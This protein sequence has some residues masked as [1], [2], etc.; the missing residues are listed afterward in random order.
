MKLPTIDRPIYKGLSTDEEKLAAMMTEVTA[1]QTVDPDDR[2]EFV[3]K[4]AQ[5]IAY[6]RY[7][8]SCRQEGDDEDDDDNDHRLFEDCLAQ[9]LYLPY[10]KRLSDA[11]A[12]GL[13]NALFYESGLGDEGHVMYTAARTKLINDQVTQ[14]LRQQQQQQ[15]RHQEKLA[16]KQKS[17]QI[18]ILVPVWIPGSIG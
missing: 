18:R 10:G 15:E 12:F 2:M 1:L 8:E 14:W 7:I 11:F 6:E 9:Y 13:R 3:H 17:Y 5:W 4:T 16:E